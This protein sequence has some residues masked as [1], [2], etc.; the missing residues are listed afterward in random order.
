VEN[1]YVIDGSVFT[2]STGVNPTATIC[3]LAKRTATYIVDKARS[4]G[5]LPARG[6]RSEQTQEVSA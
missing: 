6:A 5:A 1:L 2:T 4:E 3:A